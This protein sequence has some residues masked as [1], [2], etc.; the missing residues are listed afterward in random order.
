MKKRVYVPLALR[1]G[2]TISVPDAAA[3]H[4][5]SVV[6]IRAGD[7]LIV[8]NGAGGEYHGHCVDVRGNKI[9]LQLDEFD[10]I[11]RESCLSIT[12]AQGIARG[13]RMDLVMQK[14]VELGAKV[15]V[16]IA[17][18]RTVVRL[19]HKRA[20]KRQAHWQSIITQ[21]C[22]QSGRTRIPRLAPVLSLADHIAA[23]RNDCRIVLHPRQAGIPA[24]APTAA[25]TSVSL[26]VGPEGGF[27]EPELAAL[28]AANYRCWRLGPRTLRTETAALTALAILQSRYGDYD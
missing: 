5:R 20:A 23:D 6:R 1:I 21:A 13:A 16:P 19:D 4:L 9:S 14:S 25:P 28:N 24:F 26:L 11:D 3:H 22:E 12:V 18:K 10:P 27:D 17:A 7:E 8:F 2:A 15:I